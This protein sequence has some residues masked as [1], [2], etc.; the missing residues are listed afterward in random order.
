MSDASPP[1]GEDPFGDPSKPVFLKPGQPHPYGD[2]AP[3]PYGEHA[4]RPGVPPQSLWGDPATP[5]APAPGQY[6]YAGA[7]PGAD[8]H[9]GPMDFPAED[10]VRPWPWWIAL[11]GLAM[12]IVSILIGGALLLGLLK[13]LTD[14]D[15]DDTSQYDYL[16]GLVQDGLWIAVAIAVPLM[17]VRWIRPEHLGLRSRPLG[18][19]ALK[20]FILLFGFYVLAAVYA[21]I[22]GL[23]ESN[24]QLL[25]DTGFGDTLGKDIAYALLYPVAAPVAE[26]L[27]FRG[28]LFKGL[29]DG[30]RGAMG[31]GPAVALGA[32]I[33]G[34]IF[35]AAHINGGQNDYIPVL[36]ALGVLLA[37]AYEWSGTIYVPIAIHA[38]NNAVATA[39]SADP[40]ADWI[41]GLILLGPVLAVLLA[42]AI[43]RF[44]RR[45]RSEPPAAL[46]P[47]PQ[48]P[49]Q[50]T[51]P[52][53]Y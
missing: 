38:I 14:T 44:V 32:L 16:L 15:L 50:F 8:R 31:R 23:D 45:L 40:T 34:L 18:W 51:P 27:L 22:L 52:G 21:G 10:P 11:V 46:P 3:S 35:G 5:S 49:P 19:S 6:P 43:G 24:N 17:I 33:S 20:T 41:I 2:Q 25:Q 36:I 9:R 4:P 53:A 42:M 12:A 48:G 26:E 13:G 39:S 29:R 1:P 30:F 37:L 28:I 47:S 7:V